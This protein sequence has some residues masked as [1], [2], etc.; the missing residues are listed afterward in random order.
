MSGLVQ[1]LVLAPVPDLDVAGSVNDIGHRLARREWRIGIKSQG[2]F[3]L[4]VDE[5]R[6]RLPTAYVD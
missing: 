4:P 1:A 6:L 2:D 5:G 3:V